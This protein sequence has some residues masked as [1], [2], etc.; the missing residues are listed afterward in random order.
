[1]Q[2]SGLELARL[3]GYLPD[4]FAP[5]SPEEASGL[6]RVQGSIPTLW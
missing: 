2:L 4:R 6:C 1:M 3:G 5:D